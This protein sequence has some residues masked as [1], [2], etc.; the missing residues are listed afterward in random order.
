MDKVLS[1]YDAELASAGLLDLLQAS[2]QHAF[3]RHVVV[4]LLDSDADGSVVRQ[5]GAACVKQAC[6]GGMCMG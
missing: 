4:P 5:G 1:E 6:M 2:G 3:L